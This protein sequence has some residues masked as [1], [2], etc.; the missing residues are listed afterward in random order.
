MKILDFWFKGFCN[1]G[2]N[3]SGFLY[4]KYPNF[5]FE[6]FPVSD[7]KIYILRIKFNLVMRKPAYVQTPK[8]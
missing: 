7:W 2:L 5:G 4:K 1:S 8:A 6:E 3:Y